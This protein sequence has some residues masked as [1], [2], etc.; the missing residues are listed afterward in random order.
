MSFR[1]PGSASA[2]NS[3]SASLIPEQYASKH[4]HVKERR[5]RRTSARFQRSQHAPPLAVEG[6]PISG[7]VRLRKN[8]RRGL[9]GQLRRK[10]PFAFQQREV[11]AQTG[12]GAPALISDAMRAKVDG[13]SDGSHRTP[14]W[15]KTSP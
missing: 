7:L 13:L 11:I 14:N 4:L 1:R 6:Q 12:D 5:V 8:R 3:K 9:A 10:N 2:L 15:C